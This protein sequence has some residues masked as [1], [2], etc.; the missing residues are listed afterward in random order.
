MAQPQRA[1]RQR[2]QQGIDDDLITNADALSL[3]DTSD[4][5]LSPSFL[6]R[7]KLLEA[8]HPQASMRASFLPF[9]PM[10]WLR[11][12]SPPSVANAA[13]HVEHVNSSPS[14]ADTPLK[15]RAPLLCNM[16]HMH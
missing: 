7:R 16:L 2:L 9:A 10:S 6:T 1:R 3:L 4:E 5:L 8:S 15:A 13:G 11:K 14:D 12:A